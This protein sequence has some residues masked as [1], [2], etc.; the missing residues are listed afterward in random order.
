MAIQCCCEFWIAQSLLIVDLVGPQTCKIRNPQQAFQIIIPYI[1]P[2]PTRGPFLIAQ[3]DQFKPTS[4]TFETPDHQ[5]E[6][7]GCLVEGEVVGKS[8]H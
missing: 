7:D 2:K 3:M 4:A 8:D 5:G 1:S 6:D